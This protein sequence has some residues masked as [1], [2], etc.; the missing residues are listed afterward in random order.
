MIEVALLVILTLALLYM[1][2]GPENAE[3]F[4]YKTAQGHHVYLL[5]G[6][7]NNKEAGK[8]FIWLD[9]VLIRFLEGLKAKYNI[10]HSEDLKQPFSR[11]SIVRRL[12]RNY[13]YESVFEHLPTGQDGTSFTTNKGDKLHM[14]I[15]KKGRP[16]IFEDKN[17]IIFVAVHEMAH[18]G[19]IYWN[20]KE[21][22][23]AIFK[24]LL[25]EAVEAGIYRPVNYRFTPMHYCGLKV[26]YNPLYDDTLFHI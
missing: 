25:G 12:L 22:F 3:Y 2:F 23:W 15:R 17:S 19:N 5:K 9:G 1:L 11:A 13:N 4:R 26:D 14:C 24:F 8:I 10:N 16:H 7:S 18:M 20:H 6:F 21:D